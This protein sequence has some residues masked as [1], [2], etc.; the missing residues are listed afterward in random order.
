M[1][2][3]KEKK[4]TYT[5]VIVKMIAAINNDKIGD[6]Y[7]A[8][9]EFGRTLSTSGSNRFKILSAI[10]QKPPKMM[11]LDQMPSGLKSLLIQG[12]QREENVFLNEEV[13]RVIDTLLSEWK[14]KDV[15]D[16]HKIPVRNKIL[17]HGP[18]GNGK[19]TIA[20]YI[21]SK[22]ELPFIEINS[23]SVIDSKLGST[24]SNIHSILN[25]IQEPCVLFWDEIDSIGIKR[26][27][28]DS[29]SASHEND[30]MTNS[31]LTNMER[32]AD[33]VI[34]IGATNR[35]SV[36]DAAFL[37]RFDLK[38][39]IPAPSNLDKAKFLDQLLSYHQLPQSLHDR[40]LTQLN[41][42]SE[43]KEKIMEIGRGYLLSLHQNDAKCLELQ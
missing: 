6:F 18:T 29:S 8:A 11:R 43:I 19:T 32:L 15:Y 37:R 14:N 2:Q 4:I 30:R 34:L 24:S 5:D 31:F 26:G 20:R 16:L 3:T 23:D 22:S 9:D 39:E 38:L 42:F 41:S 25:S 40:S 12:G 7:A 13:G 27:K 10:R 36:L 17:L 33:R 21:A 28:S 35:M 1:E